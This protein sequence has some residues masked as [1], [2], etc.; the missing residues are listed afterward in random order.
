MGFQSNFSGM[1]CVTVTTEVLGSKVIITLWCQSL[2]TGAVFVP[3]ICN[4]DDPNSEI[5]VNIV[6]FEASSTLII[7]VNTVLFLF[8]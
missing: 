1:R 3:E 6:K 5:T 2:T 7:P 8:E 4:K